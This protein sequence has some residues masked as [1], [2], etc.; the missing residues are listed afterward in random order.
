MRGAEGEADREVVDAAGGPRRRA[1][2]LVPSR[3]GRMALDDQRLSIA[4]H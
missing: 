1:F 4:L 2:K 3:A